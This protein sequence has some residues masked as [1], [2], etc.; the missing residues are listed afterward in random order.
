LPHNAFIPL[1]MRAPLLAAGLAGLLSIS[2]Y[3]AVAT[4]GDTPQSSTG[5]LIHA[6]Q[7]RSLGVAE[8]TRQL[9]VSLS[10]VVIDTAT[11]APD[12]F[13]VIL[14]DQTAGIYVLTPPNARDILSGF[15]RGDWLQVN[16]VTGPGQFAPIVIANAAQKLGT[17]N[18]PAAQPVTYQQLITGALDAQW[19][20]IK[21][22]VHRIFEPAPG[23]EVGRII[24][25]ADGGLLPVRCVMQPGGPIQVDSEVRVRAVCYYQFNQKRQVLSPVL[26]VPGD[27]PVLVEK[28]A[29]ADPYS[30]PLRSAVTLLRF[31]P[32]NLYA[33]AHRVHLRG[34]V[35]FA[36][37][38]SYVWIRDGNS[39]LRI[40]TQQRNKVQ[41][42]DII[43]VLGFPTFGAYPPGLEDSVFRKAGSAQPPVPL[44]LTNFD[45]AFD[46]EDDLV[47]LNGTLTQIQ[48][49]LDGVAFTLDKNGRLFKAVLTM[50]LARQARSNWEVGS[51]IRVAGI[52]SLVHDDTRPF[53][54]VWS[55]QSF[56][57]LLRSPADL[58][59]IQ[60]PPWWTLKHVAMLLG[61]ITGALALLT[62]L[63]VTLS[64]QRLREQE[65]HR[66]MAEAEFAAILSERNRLAREIHDTLAQGL[67]ATSVQL[68]LAKKHVNGASEAF[69]RHLDA[70]L[71]LVR[72]SLREARNSIWNMRAHVL[73]TGD[74]SGALQGILKQM[75]DGTEI[76]SSLNVTGRVRRLPPVVENNVLR[77]GQEAIANAIKHSGAKQVNV[78]LE[79][80]EKRFR[81][82]VTDNGRGFDP[83]NPPPS[84]GGFGLMGMRER[85]AEMNGELSIRSA[86]GEGAEIQ[87]SIPLSGA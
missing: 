64:R 72:D 25:A 41:P 69:G 9:P 85:A 81:L 79:F 86:P 59:I 62:G 20:E 87:L 76:A 74:L 80:E 77:A 58:T 18:I 54:G 33:Y 49:V 22:V 82:R 4:G 3:S 38:G 46:H 30:A 17:T 16:G 7:V 29:P 68:R 35:T 2:F 83:H 23:S 57:I 21:G 10:G 52:C 56:Q 71:S 48:F 44:A 42:G 66:Q 6:A 51:G 36:Q 14:A 53:A 24:I 60:Q 45:E 63:V 26:Q 73:E 39:G 13:A 75:A 11:V 12:R 28:P 84:D 19:V 15:Q 27:V 5:V 40:Q 32:D 70:A 78:T 50:S 31:S 55:P 47:V 8:T 61:V 37:A 43:D 1:K 34:V 67:T 65:R